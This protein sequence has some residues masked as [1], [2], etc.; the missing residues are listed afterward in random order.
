MMLIKGQVR[1]T[2]DMQTLSYEW[3]TLQDVLEKLTWTF[4]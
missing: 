4:V 2:T 3:N 1:F